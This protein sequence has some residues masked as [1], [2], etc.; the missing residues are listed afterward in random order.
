MNSIAADRFPRDGP[1]PLVAPEFGLLIS[2]CLWVFDEI[3]IMDTRLATG[4]QLDAWRRSLHLRSGRNA[5]RPN[6]A[7]RTNNDRHLPKPCHSLWMSATIARHWLRRA[8]DWSPQVE[9]AW[10][11]CYG[12]PITAPVWKKTMSRRRH[13]SAHE[14]RRT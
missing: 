11:L 6:N 9:D 5:F 10:K 14:P 12:P 3:Q 1:G 2:D 8:V 13:P 7:F 4:L